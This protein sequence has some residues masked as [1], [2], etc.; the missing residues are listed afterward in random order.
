MDTRKLAE[1][2]RNAATYFDS[3]DNFD[4]ESYAM[5][6]EKK[7]GVTFSIGFYT[8]DKFVTAVKALGNVTKLYTEGEYSQLVVTARDFPVSVSIQRDKVCKKVVK[9]ECEPLFSVEELEE[10]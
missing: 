4:V 10:L 9:F 8:K 7:E 1:A 3:L 6:I 2:L 5:V